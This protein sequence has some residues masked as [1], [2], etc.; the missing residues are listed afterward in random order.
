M[1]STVAGGGGPLPRLGL[2][3]S[4]PAARSR[5]WSTPNGRS[6]CTGRA[7]QPELVRALTEYAYCL[8][9]AGRVSEAL[10][11]DRRLLAVCR[12]LGD[13][14]ELR[15]ALVTYAAHLSDLGWTNDI[16]D[17]LD[18]AHRIET[19][20]P[21]PPATSSSALWRPTSCSGS[22]ADPRRSSPPAETASR[23]PTNGTST[24]TAPSASA[25]NVAVGLLRAGRVAETAQLVDEFTRER[26]LRRG[27]ASPCSAFA[28]D[29]V[30]GRLEEADDRIGGAATR[31]RR[32]LRG[33]RG[34]RVRDPMR[35]VV[36]SP[37][38]RP[39]A[40]EPG[41]RR[42]GRL[43]RPSPDR[44]VSGARRPGSRRPRRHPR[45][46]TRRAAPT[47]GRTARWRR[48]DRHRQRGPAGLPGGER[49]QSSP[50][51]PADQRPELWIAAAKEWDAIG[52]PFESAYARWRGA[53]AALT[54][55][56][57]TSANRLLQRAA[58][59]AHDHAPLTSAIRATQRSLAPRPTVTRR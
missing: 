23:R 35:V 12:S 52:R 27:V 34:H 46:A 48:P 59:Q 41:A 29:T 19:P 9:L 56:R 57:G 21:T 28:L 47:G 51:S 6:P 31:L 54:T 11:V 45:R 17:L 58:R 50:D 16:R 4:G 13:A 18:E 33:P 24:P 7:A 37:R 30:R 55:G 43:L 1:P 15:H 3:G 22:A 36:G 20:R 10:E 25:S 40:P 44:R 38:P 26:F 42:Q 39:G 32:R 2:C 5:P 14:T 53:Q 49:Q 8:H